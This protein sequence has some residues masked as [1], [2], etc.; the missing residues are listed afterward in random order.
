MM[1]W[2]QFLTLS[3]VTDGE[4]SDDSQIISRLLMFKNRKQGSTDHVAS[5]CCSKTFNYS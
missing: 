3:E 1:Q 5:W 4:F 2:T